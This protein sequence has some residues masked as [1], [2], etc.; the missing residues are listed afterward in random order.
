MVLTGTIAS[1]GTIPL[2]SG[3]TEAQCKWIAAGGNM[4]DSGN[5]MANWRITTSGRVVTVLVDDAV[6]SGNYANYMIIGVK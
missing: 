4:R 6:V 2:P 3:Y 1:G 5:D